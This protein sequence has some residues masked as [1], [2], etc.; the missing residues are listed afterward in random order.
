M[1][2]RWKSDQTAST[3]HQRAA[4]ASLTSSP[5]ARPTGSAVSRGRPDGNP[6]RAI[7]RICPTLRNVEAIYSEPANSKAPTEPCA[8]P[9]ES[10]LGFLIWEGVQVRSD[11]WRI[12]GL[13]GLVQQFQRALQPRDP[14]PSR[15]CRPLPR[16]RLDHPPG[17]RH[18]GRAARRM[19]RWPPYLGV[20]VLPRSQAVTCYKE[21]DNDRL[22]FQAL[23]AS[24]TTKDQPTFM[25]TQT[26]PTRQ[27][28]GVN[29]SG[30]AASGCA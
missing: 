14:P 26:R 7:L 24:T 29:H 21:P 27:R 10:L 28:C 12:G 17:R 1:G 23:T 15:R 9:S 11:S 19:G 20:D 30:K 5:G 13:A 18:P 22:T 3:Q 4:A 6:P 8:A 25:T 2:G 16:P